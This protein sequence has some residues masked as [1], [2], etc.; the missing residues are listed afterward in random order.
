[1]NA[2]DRRPA[3]GAFQ[4]LASLRGF[5]GR[6]AVEYQFILKTASDTKVSPS[7][8]AGGTGVEHLAF[9]QYK[10][11]RHSQVLAITFQL[12]RRSVHSASHLALGLESWAD[13]GHF[14]GGGVGYIANKSVSQGERAPVGSAANRN[15]K[16]PI[17]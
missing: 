2:S 3:G 7:P 17:S 12:E 14:K 13:Q 15:P 5:P 1:M 8:L 9:G 6:A 4:Y 11:L 10:R 16:A